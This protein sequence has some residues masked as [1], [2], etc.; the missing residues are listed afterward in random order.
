MKEWTVVLRS[1]HPFT[2]I[3]KDGH[4]TSASSACAVD[5]GE[6]RLAERQEFKITMI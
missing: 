6:D 5:D 2:P 3:T 4:F 1:N